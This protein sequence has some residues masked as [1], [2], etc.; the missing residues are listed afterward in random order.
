MSACSSGVLVWAQGVAYPS[1]RGTALSGILLLSKSI[2]YV[3]FHGAAPPQTV[4]LILALRQASQGN[5]KCGGNDT[6]RHRA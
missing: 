1:S 6:T 4:V 2:E 3:Y 5:S